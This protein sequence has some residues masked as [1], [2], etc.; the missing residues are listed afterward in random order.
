MPDAGEFA[1]L[2]RLSDFC[3][4]VAA[5]AYEE[6]ATVVIFS[7]GRVF[8]DLVGVDDAVVTE[9][10]VELHRLASLIPGNNGHLTFD[11]L[12]EYVS[13]RD[14]LL[15]RYGESED[16]VSAA[17]RAEGEGL[18]VYRGFIAFLE[19]DR[20]PWDPVKYPSRKSVK[21]ECSRIAKQMMCRNLA[22]SRLVGE[23]YP[24]AVRISIHQH[25]NAGPKFA[26]RLVAGA[27]GRLRTPWHNA[28]VFVEGPETQEVGEEEP[29][30]M[31]SDQVTYE[32]PTAVVEERFGRPWAFR[33]PR[34][35]LRLLP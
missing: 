28:A 34:V 19:K 25:T 7:D 20:A 4:A 31:H 26:V 10:G 30:L 12:D 2:T 11:S 22:F 32:W 33:V 16:F 27:D 5:S 6:G 18:I 1:A 15:A 8:A 23:K 24:D 21:R 14:E 35:S 13:S 29:V 9:Y 17:I 3:G